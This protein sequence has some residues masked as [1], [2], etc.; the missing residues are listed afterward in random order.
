MPNVFSGALQPFTGAAQQ[1]GVKYRKVATS[2]SNVE[3][4][5]SFG[6]AAELQTFEVWTVTLTAGYVPQVNDV[7]TDKD[8]QL[9]NVIRVDADP[10]VTSTGMPTRF[11]L[12]ARRPK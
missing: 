12:V 11:F 9:W 3:W 2:K 1:T 8:G 7:W 4:V 10:L 5:A 6:A